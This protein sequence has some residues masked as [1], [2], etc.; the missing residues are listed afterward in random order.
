MNLLDLAIRVGVKDEASR[1]I[2]GIA[3]GVTGKLGRAA[4]GA[5]V[6]VG[7]A[8][9]AVAAGTV[10]IGKAAMESYAQYEQLQGGVAKLFGAGGKSLEEYAKS[11]GMSVDAARGKYDELNRAQDIV[12]QN[13]Q[14]AFRTAGM[15][16]NQYMEQATGFSAAL[17]TSLGGDTV[18]AAQQADVAMRAMSDNVNTFGSNMGDVQ[19]AFQGFAKQNYT[20]LDNL[21]LGYG[22]TKEEMQRLIDDANAYAA[23]IGQASDLSIDSFSDIVTA[24][25][26]IQEQQGIAGTTAREAATTIEGSVNMAKAAWQN[27]VTEL[28]KDNAD[29]EARTTEL[30]ES[31]ATAA[32]NIIPRVGVIFQSLL[33]A[34]PGAIDQIS[35]VLLPQLVALG[36]QFLQ[37][38][39]GI[40]ETLF[41]QTLP[42]LASRLGD[43]LSSFDMASFGETVKGKIQEVFATL[44]EWLGNIDLAAIGETIRQ[45]V[46]EVI[47]TLG[48]WLT[49]ALPGLFDFAGFVLS[50]VMTLAEALIANLPTLATKLWEFLTAAIDELFTHLPEML[51]RLGQ[52]VTSIINGVGEFLTA[53]EGGLTEFLQHLIQDIIDHGPEI[54][55]AA[56]EF[57][58]NVLKALVENA[59]KI[60]EGLLRLI[61]D[62]VGYV[63]THIPDILAAALQFFLALMEGLSNVAGQLLGAVGNLI[64]RVVKPIAGSVGIMLGA[65]SRWFGGLVSGAQDKAGELVNWVSGLPRRILN[66]LGNLGNLLLNAGKSI[67]NGLW[68]GMKSVW[69]R[70]SGW[71]GGLAG[72]IASLKGPLPYDKVVLIENGVA[73][74]DG[75]SRGLHEQ[76]EGEVL[77]YVSRMAGEMGSA[78]GG[79]DFS[80]NLT[81][82]TAK[83]AAAANAPNVTVIIKDTVIEKEA[84]VDKVLERA[85]DIIRRKTGGGISWS[86]SF[87]TAFA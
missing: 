75:L 61:I 12:M 86:G 38:V 3:G 82:T 34:L 18:K 84:D 77:P 26:L 43:W 65:A 76:F 54:L 2:D 85:E 35:T 62:L 59:P 29:M 37:T 25:E 72:K 83:S 51:E 63:I 1:K 55:S 52:F 10:A 40:V 22:G 45:K 5:A 23:S 31:I 13:A 8:V 73:L 67:L 28:G 87:T 36:S 56:M 30:V 9:A 58:G 21:K 11:V 68:N 17:I 53:S 19:N 32:Q 14:Q 15:S 16:A 69:D 74:M 24:I 66:A 20:M 79:I 46:E 42:T 57:F 64:G 41:T 4:K 27:W 49:A 33:A 47:N 80:T 6:A 39:G 44:S 81:A 60:L 70:L 50:F 7:A 71:V 78:F 48:D